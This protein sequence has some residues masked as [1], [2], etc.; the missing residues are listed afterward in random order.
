[1]RTRKR[2]KRSLEPRAGGGRFKTLRLRLRKRAADKKL[3]IVK[4]SEPVQS[5]NP[6]D[7]DQADHQ[8]KS[9]QQHFIYYD[10]FKSKP[11][12]KKEGVRSGVE[13]SGGGEEVGDLQCSARRARKHWERGSSYSSLENLDGFIPS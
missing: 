8:T 4:V 11:R 2:K 5:S 6:S 9:P 13:C 1:M 10:E 7:P 3:E 12:G